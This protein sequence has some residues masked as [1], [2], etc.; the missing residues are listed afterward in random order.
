MCHEDLYPTRLALQYALS[1]CELDFDDDL[2]LASSKISSSENTTNLPTQSHFDSLS[3]VMMDG[4]EFTL[5][6]T[7]RTPVADFK[8]AAAR[9]LCVEPGR[10]RLLYQAQEMKVGFGEIETVMLVLCTNF[11]IAIMYSKFIKPRVPEPQT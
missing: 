9:R 11:K 5:P 6:V 7:A 2:Q 4:S 1:Q 3:V 8:Q 10:L